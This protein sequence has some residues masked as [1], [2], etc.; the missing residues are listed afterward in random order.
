MHL[1]QQS[2]RLTRLIIESHPEVMLANKALVLEGFPLGPGGTVASG[3]IVPD[4]G[5]PKALTPA[6]T[7]FVLEAMEQLTESM[8]GAAELALKQ[9]S[10]RN[11]FTLVAGRAIAQAY[12]R[13]HKDS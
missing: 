7:A 11:R 1:E 12:S 3:P 8:P 2:D 10:M 6:E 5:F 4:E 13:M 9:E